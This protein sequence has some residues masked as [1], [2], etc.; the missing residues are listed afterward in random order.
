MY[1]V[2]LI[3]AFG[4]SLLVCAVSFKGF[5]EL[6][7][8]AELARRHFKAIAPYLSEP[9]QFLYCRDIAELTID[10]RYPGGH[11]YNPLEAMIAVPSWPA[12]K[13]Q[14]DGS[15]AHELHHLGRWQNAG[16]GS[17]LGDAIVS[18]GTAV[19]YA[20][21]ATGWVPPWARG[22]VS[23]AAWREALALWHSKGYDHDAWFYRGRRGRWVGYRM[24]Y[25]L[26]EAALG[27]SFD[28]AASFG[29]P[30]DLLLQVAE[31]LRKGV[32][33]SGHE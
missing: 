14:L 9:I 24:G 31:D 33:S 3:D 7:L 2:R 6:S 25:A 26:I 18:E 30:A 17:T 27:P 10:R 22:R 32:E 12:N 19:W 29:M 23:P 13:A 5:A 4:R 1:N 11:A 20:G 21:R 8:V 28:L 16:Y 15:L